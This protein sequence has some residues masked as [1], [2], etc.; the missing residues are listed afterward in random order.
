MNE[1]KQIDEMTN[2][3]DEE[4]ASNATDDEIA[5]RYDNRAGYQLVNYVKVGLPVYKLTIQ[6]LIQQ[7]KSISPIEEFVLRAIQAGLS[8]QSEISGLLG[9][10]Q[11]IVTETMV[12]LRRNEDID[13]IASAPSTM[14]AWKLTKKGENT[15]Q[16]AKTN[17]PQKRTFT[18]HYDGIL[19]K[20]R[21]YG[22][23]ED[24]LLKP[25]ELK[26]QG[27]TEIPPIPNRPPD[28]SDCQLKDVDNI[29]AKIE[30]ETKAKTDKKSNL[31]ALKAIEKS[32]R[33][34]QPALAL[35]FK[36]QDERN[37]QMAFIIDRK[38]S[39]EHESA[40]A[41]VGGLEKRRIVENLQN[42]NPLTLAEQTFGK[43]FVQTTDLNKVDALQQNV[44]AI[45]AQ[46]NKVQTNLEQVVTEQEKQLLKNQIEELQQQK[47]NL[48][49]KIEE[50]KQ[51]AEVQILPVY[52][53]RPLLEKVLE[54]SQ[55]R[56]MIIS[57]WIRENAMRDLITPLKQ[58][59][60]KH[61]EVFIGY[62]IGEE[63]MHKGAKKDKPDIDS[64]TKQQMVDLASKYKNF[65]F[66][67][68]GNTHAKILIADTKLAVT[69]SFNWLSF[70]GDTEKP[71]RD[72]RGV[73]VQDKLKIEQLFNDYKK[74]F[75][76]TK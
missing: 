22:D 62:G 36:A 55:E 31:L 75:E 5:K 34:Y 24:E 44:T 33:F 45:Q 59:L 43:D 49:K 71:F 39:E 13:L 64:K 48:L 57:P 26:N 65:H 42:S 41:Y 6:A 37:P 8:E 38:L 52:E 3:N 53:H 46:R 69:T 10:E 16:Q 63:K 20:V 51:N 29:I 23:L 54:E 68:L 30:S 47:E 19:R 2:Q 73:L 14:Q 15:L 72:E 56:L 1:E 4:L 76:E 74:Q 27:A 58:L 67:R 21:W 50:L 40:F 18:I 9:L 32:E 35:I 11:E 70:K 17:V 28:I 66:H 25:S 7:Q 60:Q 12:T 61:V